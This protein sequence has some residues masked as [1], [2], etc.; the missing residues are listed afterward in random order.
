MIT[1]ISPVFNRWSETSM[2]RDGGCECADV[3]IKSFKIQVEFAKMSKVR[4]PVRQ[5]KKRKWME[6][7]LT[8]N[9]YSVKMKT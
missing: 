6:R 2:K 9:P 8:V 1:I 7:K 3:P 4:L 5:I